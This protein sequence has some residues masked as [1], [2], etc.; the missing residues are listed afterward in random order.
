MP[1]TVR[2][3]LATVVWLTG[4]DHAAGELR[5]REVSASW[6]L[7]FRHHN[8][9]SGKRYYP[10][11]DG[12]GLAL[13]DF[14]HDGDLDVLFVD[15]APLP[16]YQ[17]DPPRSVLYRNDGSGRF[18]DRM[19]AAKLDLR[20]YGMGAASADFDADGD[21]DLYVTHLR[22]NQLFRNEGDGTFTDV[23]A[24]A[25]VG[26]SLWS[27]SAAFADMDRD[28][29]LDLY[30]A[31]YIDYSLEDPT[32][33][34]NEMLGIGA[35]CHPEL[36]DA[37]P[38]RFYRNRGDATFEDATAAAELAVEP[39]KAMGVIVVD[40]D[41]DGWLDVYVANDTTPNHLF[42]NRGDGTFQ[43]TSL[44][45]GTSFGDSG[46]A[47]AGMGVT[48]ADVDGDSRLDIY[49]TNFSLETNALYL[50]QGSSF[51]V[52]SRSV[53]GLAQPSL[54][55]LGF[56]T[57]F[58][59]FDLDG[60]PD[61]AVANGHILDNV[62][63][64]EEREDMT[65]RQPNQ[66]FENLGRGR[67]AEVKDSGIDVVLASR[68][69]ARG[70]LDGDGDAD[71]AIT[72]SNDRV[73]VYENVGATGAGWLAVDLGETPGGAA[74]LGARVD[75]S[76]GGKRQRRDLLPVDSYLSQSESLVR[77][78]LGESERVESLDVRWVDGA[79]SRFLDLPGSRRVRVRR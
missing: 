65:Y 58:E 73:E 69:L 51:F 63:L 6:D 50:N 30:V 45:S 72:N 20:G 18:V 7:D 40:L 42:R 15:G 70:D 47:E 54:V 66:L 32:L 27:M 19:E 35:F 36:F 38:D 75:V 16:G 12:S 60:D 2:L 41:D 22:D 79:R 61:L 23:T 48:A 26:D 52:D 71:L 56:G 49:V 24:A 5:F 67:F 44:L 1:A 17:G 76:A 59:D 68:G 74:A 33:C 37:L 62:E 64:M 9:G 25:G 57:A 55:P 10:E 43:D 46:V 39:G 11:T 31:N 78:G 53:V 13:F 29:D 21:L 14:D 28:G 77:F 8:G 4:A 3:S 34:F